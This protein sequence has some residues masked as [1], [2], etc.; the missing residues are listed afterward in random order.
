ML[1]RSTLSFVILQSQYIVLFA[2][3]LLFVVLSGSQ[4]AQ[5]FMGMH[6]YV[7]LLRIHRI[8]RFFFHM[9]HLTGVF[10]LFLPA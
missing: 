2:F 7:G 3:F 8:I 1:E 10:H 4:A 5:H 6:C 9:Y